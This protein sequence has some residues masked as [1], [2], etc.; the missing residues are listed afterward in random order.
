MLTRLR[1][2]DDCSDSSFTEN[3]VDQPES[4]CHFNERSYA[5][6]YKFIKPESYCFVAFG[7]LVYVGRVLKNVMM[8]TGRSNF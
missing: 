7:N 3:Q 4:N 2:F 8:K 6:L 1:V 5:N